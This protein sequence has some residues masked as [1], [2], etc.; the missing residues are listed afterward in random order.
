MSTTLSQ[1]MIDVEFNLND[2]H[3]A[4][5]LPLPYAKPP[6]RMS[7]M[8]RLALPLAALSLA[9][10]TS[11]HAAPGSFAQSD[12]SGNLLAYLTEG[13]DLPTRQPDG[14]FGIPGTDIVYSVRKDDTGVRLR[15]GKPGEPERDLA[16]G[17][18][19]RAGATVRAWPMYVAFNAV[20]AENGPVF[21][22]GVVAKETA[23]RAGGS[24]S[25]ERLYLFRV[26]NPG[27]DRARAREMVSLPI[28]AQRQIPL[29]PSQKDKEA[30]QDNCRGE[31]S[32]EAVLRLDTERHDAWPELVYE[33]RASARP[34]LLMAEKSLPDGP[35]DAAQ[36]VRQPDTLCS[37][38]RAIRYDPLTG[39]YEMQPATRRLAVPADCSGYF[40][41]PAHPLQ[42][43]CSSVSA[44]VLVGQTRI[45]D[46]AARQFSGARII[47]Q[48]KPGDTTSQD[49]QADRLTIET[50]PA[51]G[52][53]VKA[54]CG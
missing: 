14:G 4:L 7:M 11:T 3:F 23:E 34:G 15:F 33:S 25:E 28:A 50:D 32:Y 13:E 48:I 24:V 41:P 49:Q 43:L 19:L 51:S 46:G 26:D 39:R 27:T 54:Y 17:L 16:A 37:V 30:R 21:L 2:D 53:I 29:C 42:S 45:N 52:R 20:T 12:R 5:G 6:V 10:I 44:R 35:L 1:K 36:T 22:L 8:I 38:Q 18:S 40:L 31:L 9:A 47:R